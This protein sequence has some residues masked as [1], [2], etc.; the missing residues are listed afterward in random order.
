M[1]KKHAKEGKGA[2]N[3]GGRSGEKREETGGS[4]GRGGGEGETGRREAGRGRAS[5]DGGFAPLQRTRLVCLVC[6][7]A[8]KSCSSLPLLTDVMSG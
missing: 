5:P 3:E 1:K 7:Q 2:Q 6:L 4:W 8:S